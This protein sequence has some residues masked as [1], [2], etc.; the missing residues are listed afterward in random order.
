MGWCINWTG[1]QVG[2]AIGKV[3]EAAEG[4]FGVLD[5]QATDIAT[6]ITK[7]IVRKTVDEAMKPNKK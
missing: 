4:S 6:Q 7:D 5:N 2:N 3:A 1:K